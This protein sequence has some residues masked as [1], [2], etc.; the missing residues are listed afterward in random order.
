MKKLTYYFFLALVPTMSCKEKYLPALNLPATSF[1]VVEG[2]INSGSGATNITLSRTIKLTDTT[3]IL[4][5]TKA[6]VRVEGKNN[7]SAIQLTEGTPGRYTIAQL[8]LNPNDQY[9]LRIKTSNGK[10]YVSDFSA[11]R[12]TPTIDSISW[13]R[14]NAGV[15]IYANTHDPLAKTRYYQYVYDETWEFHSKYSQSLKLTYGP[16]GQIKAVGYKDS[17]T[18]NYDST[19]FKCWKTANITAIAIATSEQLS[20]DVISLKKIQFIENGSWKLS[21][22]YSMSVKQRAL[23]KDAYRFLEQ[24]KKNTEQIGSIF[25]AQPSENNGNIK[26]V[27]NPN[28]IAIGFVE[29]TE[30][31]E[32]RLWISKSSL[33]NWVWNTGCDIEIKVP[34]HPDS[35]MVFMPPSSYQLTNVAETNPSGT[36]ITYVFGAASTCVDC[37]LLGVNK[38]PAFWP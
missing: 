19:V 11:V 14:E 37:R 17:S 9:R 10:E 28:E 26:C 36:V 16:N 6:T 31:K 2:Y 18:F 27:S 21:Q 23:S 32:K 20:L 12:S 35:L 13:V 29:V 4:Y 30:E 38:K 22:L 5:E 33:P 25:D 1:L 34:N 24:L 7:T 8:T 15:Q 3:T